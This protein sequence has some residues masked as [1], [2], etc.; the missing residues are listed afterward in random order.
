MSTVRILGPR[1]KTVGCVSGYLPCSD[2]P[3]GEICMSCWKRGA[4]PNERQAPCRGREADSSIRLR[5]ILD[6][7]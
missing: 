6:A 2:T 5:R 1:S 4:H 7:T 3:H